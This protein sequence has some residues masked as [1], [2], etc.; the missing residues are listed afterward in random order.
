MLLG[1]VE[2]GLR[3]AGY[4]YPTGFFKKIRVG[5]KDYFI[6]NEKFTLRFSRRNWRAGPI[7]LCFRRQAAG[8]GPYFHFGES[9]AMGDPQPAY[10]PGRYLEVLLRQRSRKKI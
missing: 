8:H 9:A 6:N 2:A 10:G 1:G 4:G 3:L 5:D 7:H